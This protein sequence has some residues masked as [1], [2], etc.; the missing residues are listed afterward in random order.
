MQVIEIPNSDLDTAIT[1]NDLTAAIQPANSRINILSDAYKA[2]ILDVR[3]LNR[4]ARPN[5]F[6]I[7][8]HVPG[9]TL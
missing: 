1:T 8:R 5:S 3:S 7:K 6:S 2:Q 4:M 9:Y